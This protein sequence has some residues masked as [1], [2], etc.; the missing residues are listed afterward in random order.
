MMTVL[1]GLRD[2]LATIPGV[3]SCA[4]GV[5]SNISP[6]DYPMI[7][8]VP[9]R[10]TL[11]RPYDKRTSETLIYFGV[12]KANSE[13]LEKVYDEL[14]TLEAL[15]IEKLKTLDCRYIE[16]ITDED[17]LDTYKLMTI[18]AEVR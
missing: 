12:N 5:E 9:S 16:T 14:F 2:A 6:I 13:G 3:K 15:I 10:I 11:G 7:R 4:I 17:R 18:R 1:E 8:I